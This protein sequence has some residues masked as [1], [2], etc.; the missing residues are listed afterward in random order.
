MKLGVRLIYGDWR[1][2][3]KEAILV[4]KEVFQG[5]QKVDPA[6]D[7]DDKDIICKHVVL[8]Y[9]NKPVG[10]GR[11]D[12]S[13]KIGRVAVLNKFRKSG[14][15]RTIVLFLE[16]IA[17]ESGGLRVWCHAQKQAEGFYLKLGYEKRG[18]TFLEAGIEHRDMEKEL[19]AIR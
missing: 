1:D 19:T 2:V 12:P 17:K 11:I 18:D 6:L 10:T 3:A 14:H 16:K 7:F 4:R 13:G 15:G 5:E 9:E 8:Y